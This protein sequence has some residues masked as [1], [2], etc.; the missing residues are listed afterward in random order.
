MLIMF[1]MYFKL[2][3]LRILSDLLT[4]TNAIVI[5]ITTITVPKTKLFKNEDNE[6][7]IKRFLFDL[8]I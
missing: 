4:K 7:V 2:Y 1:K 3:A 5:G 6:A 8:K